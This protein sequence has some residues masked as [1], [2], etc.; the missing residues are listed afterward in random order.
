M[1]FS[2]P[3]SRCKCSLTT[4]NKRK[5]KTIDESTTKFDSHIAIL[6]NC[7]KKKKENCPVFGASIFIFLRK[8]IDSDH[9]TS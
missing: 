4:K 5:Q 8:K 9:K 2:F 6:S 1:F 7:R 3:H